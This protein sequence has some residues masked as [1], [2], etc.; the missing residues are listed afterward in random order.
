MRGRGAFIETLQYSALSDV[1]GDVRLRGID[2][3][4]ALLSGAVLRMAWHSNTPPAIAPALEA[5]PKCR[6]GTPQQGLRRALFEEV[7]ASPCRI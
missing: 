3:R 2:A 6:N 5:A 1:F 7:G 4:K